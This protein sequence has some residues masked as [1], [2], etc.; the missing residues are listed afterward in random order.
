[1]EQELQGHMGQTQDGPG[2]ENVPV[3]NQNSLAVKFEVATPKGS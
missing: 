1:M 3:P 2:S